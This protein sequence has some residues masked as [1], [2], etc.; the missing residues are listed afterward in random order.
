[1][2]LILQEPAKTRYHSALQNY[3]AEIRATKQRKQLAQYI[4]TTKQRRKIVE[5]TS[6]QSLAY[7]SNQSGLQNNTCRS[8]YGGD[9]MK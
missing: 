7:L 3:I 2:V 4:M 9:P 5:V 6:K 1:M 8:K